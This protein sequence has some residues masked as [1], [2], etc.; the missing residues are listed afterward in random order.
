M[1][2]PILVTIEFRFTTSDDPA[3]LAERVRES[4]RLIVGT[5]ALEEFRWR[6]LP[7]SSKPTG[8]GHR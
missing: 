1:S 7:L 6:G 5:D 2:D 3:Q 8:P 4:V